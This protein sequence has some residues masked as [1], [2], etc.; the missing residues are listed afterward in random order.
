[1]KNLVILC[2]VVLLFSLPVALVVSCRQQSEPAPAL[3]TESTIASKTY[4]SSVYG[5]SFEYPADW[6]INKNFSEE[7]NQKGVLVVFDGP[8]SAIYDHRANI[9]VEADELSKDFTAEEY[10]Q[11]VELRLLKITLPDYIM[12]EEQTTT[13]SEIPAIIRTFTATMQYYPHKDIQAYFTKDNLCYTITY[14][15]TIDSHDEYAECFDLLINSF[16]FE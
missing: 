2:I 16:K 13:I 4:T 10:A 7:E 1:M 11:A 9:I 6:T 12:L 14:D 5:F 15:V 8:Q 3:A